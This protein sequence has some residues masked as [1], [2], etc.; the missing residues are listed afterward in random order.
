MTGT[1]TGRVVVSGLGS[2]LRGDDGVG[3]AVLGALADEDAL[4]ASVRAVADPLSL[5]DDWDCCELSVVVDAMRSGVRPG[6]VLVV[7]L[8]PAAADGSGPGPSAPASTH[9]LGLVTVLALARALGRLPRRVVL[10]GVEGERFA[11]GHGLSPAVA[12]AVPIAAAR[13]RGLV[14]EAPCA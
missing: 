9:A 14:E 12:R 6:T 11:L 8:V 1:T 10:V 7:P 4:A 5:L 13:V 3:P 2:E